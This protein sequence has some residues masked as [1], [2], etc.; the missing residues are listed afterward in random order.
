M[1]DFLQHSLELVEQG[2][3]IF[4]I[5]YR[6]KIPLT[7]HGFKDATT[8]VAQIKDWNETFKQY[9][10][11]IKTG[12]GLAVIDVDPKNG[13]TESWITLTENNDLPDTVCS[14]TGGG[15]RHYFF[16]GD[17]KNSASKI[18]PGIDTRGEG[19]YIVAPP[20]IHNTGKS[21]AWLP[22]FSPD[23]MPLAPLPDFLNPLNATNFYLF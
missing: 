18:A 16:K 7:E 5:K 4:P 6:N 12:D 20:S 9:N 14:E 10:I 13:G 15:G 2:F 21:Y 1:T 17:I 8:S 22:G 19:G 23:E 3:S 11:G